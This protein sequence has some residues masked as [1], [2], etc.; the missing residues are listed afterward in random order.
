MKRLFLLGLLWG[1]CNAAFVD[2]T[3]MWD[4]KLEPFL[5][6]DL[7]VKHKLRANPFEVKMV[8]DR[9][10]GNRDLRSKAITNVIMADWR[11][12]GNIPL[13]HFGIETS[14]GV[15]LEDFYATGNQLITVVDNHNASLIY[16]ADL[17][18]GDYL[19]SHLHGVEMVRC[20]F[21]KVVPGEKKAQVCFL[22]LKPYEYY[23]V[24]RSMLLVHNMMDPG[25]AAALVFEGTA[26]V[27][28]GVDIY[29]T[30][31]KY[32]RRKEQ[33]RIEQSKREAEA[34]AREFANRDPRYREWAMDRTR[35]SREPLK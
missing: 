27:A 34:R 35:T 12:N 5:M 14:S 3:V 13:Y 7:K 11:E 26:A 2:T 15:A 21:N 10:P 31:M 29:R 16:L 30:A 22:S 23:Y 18:A 19:V 9:I 1:T 17:K 4:S 8:L 24:G 20:S 25:T 32:E 33:E 28:A 6:K